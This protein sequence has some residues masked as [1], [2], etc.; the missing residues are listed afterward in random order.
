MASFP[1]K[2]SGGGGKNQ[3]GGLLNPCPE[4]EAFSLF[5][6]NDLSAL[7][8]ILTV[9]KYIRMS[10]IRWTFIKGHT[11]SPPFIAYLPVAPAHP[12]N[13]LL[14]NVNKGVDGSPDKM[15]SRK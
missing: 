4:A 14:G 15:L 7:T 12:M 6:V 9:N 3:V 8:D 5:G 1:L 10:V 2:L 11:P 13:T